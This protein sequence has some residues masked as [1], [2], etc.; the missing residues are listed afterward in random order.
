[1]NMIKSRI[2]DRYILRE[3]LPPFFLSIAVLTLA[4]FLQKM[5]RLV[6][7]VTSKGSTLAATGKLILYILPGFLMITVPLSLLVAALTAFSRMSADSEVTAMKASRVSLYA[8]IRPVF[9]FAVILFLV[10][11]F[12]ANVLAPRANSALKAHLFSLVKSRAMVGIEAGVFS[13]TFDGM[14]IYVDR[15][16]SLD[17]MQGIFISDERTAAEPYAIIAKQ[18]KLI[19]NPESFSVTLDLQQGAV[20]LPPKTETGY[21][22]MS[23]AT[24]KLNLDLQQGLVR[25]K[26]SAGRDIDETDSIELLRQLRTARA[27]G[28]PSRGAEVELHKRLSV[29][30]ACLVFGI[31]GVPLGIRKTR[32]GKSAGVAVAIAVILVYYL[33]L[34]TGANLAESGALSPASAYWLPNGLITIVTL[35]LVVKKGQEI[36]FGIT[37]RLGRWMRRLRD[38]F[39]KGPGKP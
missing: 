9:T 22:L 29:S 39:R 17:D 28:T 33:I 4:L 25:R 37:A 18:G 5:F 10:T 31:V 32:T 34:G 20:H 15:M 11:A 19:T 16:G 23:F 21:S 7:L 26:E 2:L 27:A 38:L 30:Y 35:L 6:E 3:L 1:M 14:V 13:S 8:M 12:I 24:G 36:S